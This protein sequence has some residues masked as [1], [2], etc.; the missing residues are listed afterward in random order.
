VDLNS[1]GIK[2]IATAPKAGLPPKVRRFEGAMKVLDGLFATATS[3]TGGIW[4]D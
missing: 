2:E 4:L 1:D 3:F